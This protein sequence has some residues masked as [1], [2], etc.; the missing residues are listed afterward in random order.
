MFF[1]WQYDLTTCARELATESGGMLRLAIAVD[2]PP[3][4]GTP[5]GGQ[6]G[7]HQQAKNA[8]FAQFTLG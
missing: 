4:L 7:D 8:A 3:F 1:R 2:P 6:G 5:T